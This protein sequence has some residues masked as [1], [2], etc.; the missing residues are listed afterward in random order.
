[1]YNGYITSVSTHLS[2]ETI[3]ISTAEHIIKAQ[4]RPFFPLGNGRFLHSKYSYIHLSV[5][6]HPSSLP[7]NLVPHTAGQLVGA[8]CA[9]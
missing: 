8:I 2:S 7:A 9:S 5:I 1:M 3:G 6:H 4:S